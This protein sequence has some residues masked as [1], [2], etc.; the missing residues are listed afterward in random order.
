ML[1]L[2]FAKFCNISWSLRRFFL[3]FMVHF[4][5]ISYILSESWTW[6]ATLINSFCSEI[7]N[8]LFFGLLSDCDLKIKTDFS[9]GRLLIQEINAFALLLIFYWIKRLQIKINSQRNILSF[10]ERACIW[11]IKFFMRESI[12]RL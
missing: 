3:C 4:W 5:N 11:K 6:P 10:A 12:C 1:F 7:L 8:L 2:S 9:V